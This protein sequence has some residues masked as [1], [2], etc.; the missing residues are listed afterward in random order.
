MISPLTVVRR[1][2]R[3]LEPTV[4][5][6]VLGAGRR[7]FHIRREQEP[8]A[9]PSVAHCQR[10]LSDLIC[11][12]QPVITEASPAAHSGGYGV[13]GWDGL[14]PRNVTLA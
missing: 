6:V 10:A 8:A 14:Q 2:D 4:R 1:L 9:V 12:P 11:A 7:G 5:I 3:V 13:L